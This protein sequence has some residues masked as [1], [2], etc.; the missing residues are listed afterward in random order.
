MRYQEISNESD[1]T[2]H[3]R[4]QTYGGSGGGAFKS[5][6]LRLSKPS[7]AKR[8]NER[9]KHERT[10][11]KRAHS[12]RS[13]HRSRRRITV[14]VTDPRARF[15][16]FRTICFCLFQSLLR[17]TRRTFCLVSRFMISES[18]RTITHVFFITLSLLIYLPLWSL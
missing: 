14:L 1:I 15:A 16:Q 3:T 11:E 18:F 10:Y 5:S 17:I 13:R 9:K 8:R 7:K 12:L 2:A 4:P 6:R